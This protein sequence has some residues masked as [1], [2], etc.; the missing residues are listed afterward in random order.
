MCISFDTFAWKL[1]SDPT[2]QA[3]TDCGFMVDTYGQITLPAIVVTGGKRCE[4]TI[5]A[6]P[7]G[8]HTIQAKFINSAAAAGDPTES[9]LSLP[10][11]L[12]MPYVA[13]VVNVI[14]APTN[15]SIVP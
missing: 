14:G 12:T 8:A 6:L 3:V 1:V 13:P 2:A 15:M 4:A 5:D 9:S 10:F 11:S 7:A